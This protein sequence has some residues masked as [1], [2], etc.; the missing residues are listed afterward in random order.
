MPH[1]IT[2]TDGHAIQ[3]L[4]TD[5]LHDTIRDFFRWLVGCGLVMIVAAA[6]AWTTLVG[7]VASN[8]KAIAATA[9]ARA[10]ES[11]D[12]RALTKKVD[13]LVVVIGNQTEILRDLQRRIR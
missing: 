3:V 9:V 1:T 11:T 8:E 2:D 13:S 7:R 5:D 10:A 4:T 6:V 12:V